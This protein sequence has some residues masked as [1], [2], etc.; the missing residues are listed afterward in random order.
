MMRNMPYCPRCEDEILALVRDARWLVIICHECGWRHTFMPAPAKS[1][2]DAAI[3][4]AVA[5][6]AR[7]PAGAPSGPHC[8]Q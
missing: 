2:L 5:Q 3:T 7:P 8:H 4:E 6:A 1:D